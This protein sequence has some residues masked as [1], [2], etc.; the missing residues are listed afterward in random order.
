MNPTGV[1]ASIDPVLSSVATLVSVSSLMGIALPGRRV[2]SL[3]GGSG[4]CRF[5]E[6]G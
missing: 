1:L 4:T 5:V 2:S 6:H 3:S